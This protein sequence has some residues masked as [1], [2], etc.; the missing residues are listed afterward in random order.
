MECS[1]ENTDTAFGQVQEPIEVS[2][3]QYS[4]GDFLQQFGAII[5]V[6]LGLALL[7][8]VLVAIV[9]EY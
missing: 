2:G 6:C 9:G 4:S 8:S 7:A 1:V 5:A 3:T